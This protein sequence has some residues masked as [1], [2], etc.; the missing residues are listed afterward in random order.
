VSVYSNDGKLYL[1]SL[2]I[3]NGY[4]VN[5]LPSGIYN[6]VV[7]QGDFSKGIRVIKN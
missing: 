1:E 6:V 3:E 5:N 7:S 2:D 4:S